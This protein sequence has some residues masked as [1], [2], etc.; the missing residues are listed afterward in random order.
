[1]CDNVEPVKSSKMSSPCLDQLN[2]IGLKKYVIVSNFKSKP[3]FN[4]STSLNHNCLSVY[5]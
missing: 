5:S 2:K 1:M 3:N 4:L